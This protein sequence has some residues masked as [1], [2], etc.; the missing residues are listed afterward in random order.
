M[1]SL[2]AL[3]V[4][5]ALRRADVHRYGVHRRWQ[6]ADLHM[7]EA[8]AS[9]RPASVPVA[10][11]L[12]G[13]FWQAKYGRRLNRPLAR[14]LAQR[15]WAAWNVEYR[16][17]GRGQDGGW[18]GTFQDVARAI[19]HLA[20]LNDARLDLNRV[21]VIGHSAGGQ[22]ALWAAGRQRLP[23]GAPG[24]APTVRVCAVVAQAAVSDLVKAG[25]PAH[26]LLGGTPEEM[27]DRYRLA[28][29]IR[30]VPLGVPTLLVH[31]ADDQTV[32]VER[33]RAY[34]AAAKAAGDDVVLV[35]SVGGGHRAPIHPGSEAW[36]KVVEW[37]RFRELGPV[38]RAA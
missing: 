25:A 30:R 32:P 11:L 7:P 6:A 13:G 5:N 3:V 20:Q 19:D 1:A 4:R 22:L 24:A 18:P 37:L 28:D 16:R 35:E 36:L 29:P 21:V 12:H 17:L 15:G 8:E 31:P 33:S 9:I 34:A 14:D 23:A 10:V 2:E 27:P 38:S 26:A